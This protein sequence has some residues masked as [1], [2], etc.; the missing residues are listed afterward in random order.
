MTEETNPWSEALEGFVRNVRTTI[1]LQQRML[2]SAAK[3]S[4][5]GAAYVRFLRNELLPYGRTIADLTVDYYKA[6]GAAAREYGA[7]FYDDVLTTAGEAQHEGESSTGHGEHLA[8]TLTGDI[9]S[10]VSATVG[11]ENHD[12]DTAEVTLEAGVCRGPAGEAFTPALRLEPSSL[13]IPP[14][15]SAQVTVTV[16]LS[17]DDFMPGVIYRLPLH[18]NGP[19]PTTVDVTI[20]GIAAASNGT[21]EHEE[22][23]AAGYAVECP[24]CSRRF[25]RTTDS[26][27]LRP[28]KTPEGRSCPQRDGR[29]AS[30]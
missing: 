18:V 10:Q 20:V 22:Q 16:D 5:A 8:L 19:R 7:A 2:R 27:R 28:H 25:S 13:S 12:P 30:R 26:L 6:L 17:P 3:P 14:G 15:D 23:A 1:D 4:E 9:G 21:S 29:R 24:T 11:L